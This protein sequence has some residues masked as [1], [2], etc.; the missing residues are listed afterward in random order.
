MMPDDN[1]MAGSNIGNYSGR[2][3]RDGSFEINGVP[4]GRYIAV[5]RGQAVRSAQLLFG[6]QLISVAGQDLMGVILPLAPGA[7]ISGT[8]SF[9]SSANQAPTDVSQ[10]RITATSVT[11]ISG[12]SDGNT[13]ASANGSFTLANVGSSAQLIRAAGPAR[14]WTLKGVFL[15][16]RD[17]S[18]IAME[19]KSGER[20]SGVSVIFTD[21]STEITGTVPDKDHQP[22]MDYL[23]VAFPVDTAFWVPQSRRIIT[24][25]PDQNGSYHLRGLPS[26][27]YLVI[28]IDDADQGQWYDPA[29]LE[30]LR[31]SAVHVAL[32]EGE[33]KSQELKLISL[34]R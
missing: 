11:P 2:T 34:D 32:A 13:R 24:S 22:M 27:D 14:P 7:T 6:R 10:V 5:A 8:V 12:E 9:E 1:R 19:F 25:R 15:G 20:V 26:G 18:D 4:P 28:A 3:M 16:G 33:T 23:V 30:Q 29:F 31:P 17:I 21:A